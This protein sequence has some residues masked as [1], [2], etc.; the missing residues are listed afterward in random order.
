M[1]TIK[2]RKE[3]T[4]NKI[5]LSREQKTNAKKEGREKKTKNS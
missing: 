2:E 5:H 1:K 4:L 3:K